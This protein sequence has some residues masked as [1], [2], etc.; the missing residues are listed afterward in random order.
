MEAKKN[1]CVECG[2]EVSTSQWVQ[3]GSISYCSIPCAD[4]AREKRQ[5]QTLCNVFEECKDE[6][7]T[8]VL[9]IISEAG[10]V[11]CP[12]RIQVK[13]QKIDC[14]HNFS[15]WCYAKEGKISIGDDGECHTYQEF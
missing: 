9:Q 15:H 14:I 5:K 2:Q 6:L 1:L 11:T 3:E 4:K 12:E 8:I 13:C 10:I 7:R